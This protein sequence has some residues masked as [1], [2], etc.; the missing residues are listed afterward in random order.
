[1]ISSDGNLKLK[2]GKL[3]DIAPTILEIMSLDI[4]V[5]MNGKS[6]LVK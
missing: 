6:L 1:M 5:A 3:A 4:P 2:N